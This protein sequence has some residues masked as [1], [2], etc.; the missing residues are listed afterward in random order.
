MWVWDPYYNMYW[1]FLSKTCQETQ[2][3][4]DIVTCAVHLF[5]IWISG[6]PI[7]VG[8]DV[9]VESLDTISEVDMVSSYVFFPFFLFSPLYFLFWQH[10]S[11]AWAQSLRDLSWVQT[12]DQLMGSGIKKFGCSSENNEYIFFSSMCVSVFLRNG[13]WVVMGGIKKGAYIPFFFLYLSLI[14]RVDL[15]QS[16]NAAWCVSSGD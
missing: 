10:Y 2:E 6:P 12:R 7:P 3:G 4:A 14:L 15:D 13:V 9:Q 5:S 11:K 16:W 1:V 8:V